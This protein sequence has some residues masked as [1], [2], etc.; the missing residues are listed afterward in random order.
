[1]TRS[2]P[3]PVL[4]ATLVRRTLWRIETELS[5]APSLADLAA[6][7]GVSR[8]HLTRAFAVATGRPVMAYVRAR[9]LSEAARRIRSTDESLLSIALDAGYDSHEG[10]ARAFRD[11]FGIPPSA[12][13][14]DPGLILRLQEPL[15]M[16]TEPKTAPEPR[17][18][19]GPARR[20]VGV[21]ESYSMDTRARIPAQWERTVE[22]FGAAMYDGETYGVCHGFDGADFR[23][24]VGVAAERSGGLDWP[25]Q[26]DLPGTRYAVFAH[27][28]HISGIS[29]TWHSIFACWEPNSNMRIAEAPQFELYSAEFDLSGSG[30][31][32]IW[33]P[34]EGG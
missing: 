21:S 33:I 20:I 26:V 34:V 4:R 23:Y 11:V 16:N 14:A 5:H 17:I 3:T 2:N 22:E 29:D 9:R 32:S 15:T 8:F 6:G 31:V 28:G 25:D 27:E 7:E 18:V 10:F 24:L 13:R 1:M 30:G 12:A 19:D